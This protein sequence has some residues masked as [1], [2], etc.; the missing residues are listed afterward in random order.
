MT[1]SVYVIGGAGTGKSTFMASLIV[2]FGF[3]LGPKEVFYRRRKSDGV[4]DPIS[5]HRLDPGGGLYIGAWRPSFPGTDGL[6]RSCTPV[7]VEWLEQGNLPPLILGEGATLAS[8]A[9]LEALHASTKL[10]VVHLKAS[11]ETVLERMEKRG[12]NQKES[13][14]RA[15][16]TRSDNLATYLRGLGNPVLE[17]RSDIPEEWEFAQDLAFSWID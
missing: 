15:T 5:G 17:M 16:V 13:F 4:M 7:G 11:P 12:S 3:T 14:I 9:F 2:Q 1:T 10:L 6:S 8:R